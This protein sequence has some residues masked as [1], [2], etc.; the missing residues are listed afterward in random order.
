MERRSG[1][2]RVRAVTLG[3]MVMCT[4]MAAESR[5]AVSVTVT[6]QKYSP[7]LAWS[8][9]HSRPPSAVV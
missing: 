5:E 3:R 4:G 1:A 6:V 9:F 2:L 7:G 8:S